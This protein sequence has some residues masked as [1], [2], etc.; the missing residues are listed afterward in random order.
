MRSRGH[1]ELRSGTWWLRIPE[2]QPDAATGEMRRRQ[3]RIRLGSHKELRSRVAARERADAWLARSRP[4]TLEPGPTVLAIE[5]FEHFIAR[6]VPLMRPT[7]RRH[8]V[9][10][11]RLHLAPAFP[12]LRLTEIDTAAAQQL[13]ADL[14][15]R[16]ARATIGGIRAILLQVLRQARRD[17]HGACHIDP[18]TVRLPKAS[19]AEREPRAI[20]AAELDQILAASEWPWRALWA[21]LG[22]AG[23]RIG[24]ALALE[25][26]HVDLERRLLRIRQASVDGQLAQLKT[27]TSR[28]D[29]PLLEVL[30]AILT[31]Y[32]GAW[33]PNDAGL[34]FATR[35]GK[36]LRADSVRTRRLAPLLE[37]LG[38]PRAGCHAFRHGLPARLNAAGASPAAIQRLLRHQSLAMTQRYLHMDAEEFARALAQVNARMGATT[39]ANNADKTA[40]P[41]PTDAHTVNGAGQLPP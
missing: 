19:S 22:Y 13:M 17:G 29:L 38:L 27:R 28:A 20:A 15:Q 36:P 40:Q 12:R 9:T 21:I 7:T 18:K 30:A 25:W 8:Y 23:L 1:L 26:R 34:L 2:R 32:R 5:Y 33:R 31:E 10:V 11:I 37:R 41:V 24:E 35:N 3:P 39:P 14:S 6:H 4:E 16:L